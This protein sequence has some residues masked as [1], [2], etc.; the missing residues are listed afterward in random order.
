MKTIDLIFSP[1]QEKQAKIVATYAKQNGIPVV[2]PV[3][4]P[5]AIVQM[6]PNFIAYTTPDALLI[7]SLAA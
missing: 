1:L 3:Q 4:M 7:Q 5:A 2:F 6:A